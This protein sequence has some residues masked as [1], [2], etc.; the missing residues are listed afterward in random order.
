MFHFQHLLSH[1]SFSL[2]AQIRC[3]WFETDSVAFYLYFVQRV[4]GEAYIL[5]DS[6]LLVCVLAH[7]P[8]QSQ[9]LNYY[10]QDKR[11]RL[12]HD[13]FD[14]QDQVICQHPCQCCENCLKLELK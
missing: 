3:D 10:K 13:I 6:V 14:V 11:S 1:T 5:V 8:I 2:V 12:L 7:L 4:Y 9:V